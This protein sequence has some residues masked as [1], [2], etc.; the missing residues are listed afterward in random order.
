MCCSPMSGN[1]RTDTAAEAYSEMN[2]HRPPCGGVRMLNELRVSVATDAFDWAQPTAIEF[3][4]LTC[5][6]PADASPSH[7]LASDYVLA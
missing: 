4:G 6:A 3:C 1:D 7:A 2:R 5:F